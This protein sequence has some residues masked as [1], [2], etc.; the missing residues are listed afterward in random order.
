MKLVV[1]S[2]SAVKAGSLFAARWG[3]PVDMGEKGDYVG[4]YKRL[5]SNSSPYSYVYVPVNKETFQ[6]SLQVRDLLL[7]L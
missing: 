5:D 1:E 4:V 2:P 6:G 7:V 3:R